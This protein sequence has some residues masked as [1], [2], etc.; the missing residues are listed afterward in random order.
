MVASATLS[1]RAAS[2]PPA[3]RRL[4]IID[5]KGQ[6]P[7]AFGAIG[8]LPS[9]LA[10][11]D[12]LI[13]NDAATLPAS[14]ADELEGVPIELR[15]M[16]WL[17]EGR[18][19]AAVLGEGDWRLPTERR[20]PPPPL[21]PGQVLRFGDLSV[22]ILETDGQHRATVLLDAPGGWLDG[23]YRQGEPVQYS[24]LSGAVPLSAFQTAFARRPWA[25]ESP[26]AALPLRW[27]VLL[28]LAAR[29]VGLATLT[30]AAGLSSI[31]GGALD[32]AL[33]PL[34]ERSDL[35][36]ETVAA[37]ERT[38]QRG[39]RV[40]A[41][42]TT[43]VRAL[44]GRRHDRGR[45]AP[46]ESETAYR[47]DGRTPPRVVDGLITKLHAPQD[48]H[49]AVLASF[50]P[51]RWLLDAFAEATSRGFLHHEFGDTALIVDVR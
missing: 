28:A 27:E 21:A 44:E 46:G 3:G 29:G 26:S 25:V 2:G 37:I 38:R 23:L 11:G 51:E 17:G 13:V 42:G 34:P 1:L 39:G 6:A 15:L 41:A 33:L 9:A 24:Y 35:P 32:A 18:W 40:I 48:S 20:G 43:V 22:E 7:H 10:P 8:D 49:F 19:E 36:A 16:R 5:R 47:L 50:A 30:H 14:L 4:V 45:L 12:L 31:D